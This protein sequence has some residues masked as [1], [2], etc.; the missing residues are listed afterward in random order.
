MLCF[1]GLNQS[2]R[3]IPQTPSPHFT[4]TRRNLIHNSSNKSHL[5]AR[6]TASP[7][8]SASQNDSLKQQWKKTQ[9][10]Q[11]TH[12][13]QSGH[14]RLN[15]TVLC[16]FWKVISPPS[17]YPVLSSAPQLL[18]LFAGIAANPPQSGRWISLNHDLQG[19]GFSNMPLGISV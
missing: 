5:Y 19:Y 18:E 13:I 14:S 7:P 6:E 3:K 9:R 16:F 1:E 4:A 8:H 11:I 10:T 17:S 2:K 15:F 12:S